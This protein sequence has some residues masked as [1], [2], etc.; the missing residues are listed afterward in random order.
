M[1]GALRILHVVHSMNHGEIE[2]ALMD[3]Y[4]NLDRSKIQFDFLTNREGDYDEEVRRLGGFIYRIS[5]KGDVG[6]KG[7]RRALRQFFKDHRYYI[8][9]HTHLDQ[10]STYA[11]WAAKRVGIPVRVAH[12][13]NTGS[14]GTFKSKVLANLVG[15]LVP[16]Y[17]TDYFACTAD[18]AKWLFKKR[19]DQVEIMRNPIELERFCYS[20]STRDLVRKE[21]NISD[22]DFVIGHIGSFIWQKN[23]DYLIELFV[24]FRR[25]IPQSKLILIGEGPPLRENIEKKINQYHIADHV[26]LLG[27]KDN[28][29]HWIQ[30]FDLIVSPSFHEAYRYL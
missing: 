27:A 16:Y 1:E 21:L 13:H 7:Y 28:T 2:T 24:G 26:I 8:I 11:L 30:A 4:R 3:V 14:E 17:A 10:M 22:K 23:H 15:S 12:S 20:Q 29:E 9:I 5:N 18:A 19:A 6:V 25:K